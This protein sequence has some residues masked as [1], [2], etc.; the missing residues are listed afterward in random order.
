MIGLI[1]DVAPPLGAVND[2]VKRLTKSAGH[3]YDPLGEVLKPIPGNWS[4]IRRIGEAYKIAGQA[5]E[6]CG[7]N[8]ESG[9]KRVDQHWNGKAAIAFN[10]WSHRQIAAMKWEG[11]TGRLI[12]EGLGA[13]SDEIREAIRIVLQ[14]LWQLLESQVKIDDVTDAFKVIFKKIPVV[15][16]GAT[17]AELAI[18]ITN[19]V[20]DALELVEKI[21]AMVDAV[22][23]F[24]EIIQDPIQAARDKVTD[25]LNE[26]VQPFAA[27]VKASDIMIDASKTA[28]LSQ[29]NN[30]PREGYNIGTGS[31]PWENA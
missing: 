30:R 29:T 2:T 22:K 18:K 20:R 31:Q 16:W 26:I 10:D 14:W 27:G 7:N 9:L 17:V 5:L 11:P 28:D 21:R 4:E 19:I 23:K 12:A 1:S 13:V 8:L 15:G 6:T 3:E 24:L 25:K